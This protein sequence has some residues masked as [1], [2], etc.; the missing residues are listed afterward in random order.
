MSLGPQLYL[1]S[2]VKYSLPNL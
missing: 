1:V 2:N